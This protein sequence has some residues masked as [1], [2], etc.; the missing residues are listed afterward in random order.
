MKNKKIIGLGAVLC[1]AGVILTGAGFAMGG[2][3][4]IYVDRNGIH[5]MGD[6]VEETKEPY[7]MEKTKLEDIQD[8]S[9]KTDFA[10]ICLIPSDDFYLE[11][12]VNGNY[13]EPV[14]KTENGELV[15]EEKLYSSDV[16]DAKIYLFSLNIP[17]FQ[18]EKTI[19][20]YVKL[21]Y[22]E[23]T[24]FGTVEL[25]SQ[26]EDIEG[27]NL[28]ADVLKL[29]NAYGD[30]KVQKLKGNELD[31]TV[32]DG[33][34]AADIIEAE[35]FLVKNDYGDVKLG[36]L[37]GG[38]G[39]ISLGDGKFKINTLEAKE[40]TLKNSYGDVEAAEISG[41]SGE[42]SLDDGDFEADTVNLETFELSD[43]SGAVRID[44][45]SGQNGRIE[46]RDGNLEVKKAEF[47][48]LQIRNTYGD[49]RLFLP[50][51]EAYTMDLETE[52]G[53]ILLPN[54]KKISEDETAS[55]DQQ[56]DAGKRL[57]ISCSDGNIEI[58]DS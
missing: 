33:D 21:Y 13:G 8:I 55:Y 52:Y 47:E 20:Y 56:G 51:W 38:S 26:D 4:G 19:D 57:E 45:Y 17:A 25:E 7:V 10:G 1:A 36:E 53:E 27:G 58:A 40:F 18:N 32:N 2:K 16:K 15:F 3:L 6:S 30:T 41:G 37:S 50:Q 28:T 24:V 34:F 42:I 46:L 39:E 48:D 5:S 23:D 35:K 11:Y 31:V 29:H 22:P 44:E 12:C 9:I 54:N 43:N 49:V 14:V